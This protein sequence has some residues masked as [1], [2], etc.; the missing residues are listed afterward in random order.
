MTRAERKENGIIR[1]TSK[2]DYIDKIMDGISN[3]YEICVKLFKSDM[4]K[5]IKNMYDLREAI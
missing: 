5:L 3:L 1:I 4:D 2:I